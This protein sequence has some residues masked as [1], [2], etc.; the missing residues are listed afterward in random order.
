MRI[1]NT[2]GPCNRQDHYMVGSINRLSG[3]AFPLIDSKQ[4]FVIHSA[5]QSGKTT[6]LKELAN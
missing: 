1:F 6:L 4:F 5:R 2:A 3:E